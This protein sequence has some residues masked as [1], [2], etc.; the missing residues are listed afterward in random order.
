[1]YLLGLAHLPYGIVAVVT[2]F[3]SVIGLDLIRIDICYDSAP[4]LQGRRRYINIQRAEWGTTPHAGSGGVETPTIKVRGP[5]RTPF[6]LSLLLPSLYASCA[7][8]HPYATWRPLLL[9]LLV[10]M[11]SS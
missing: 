3:R 2:S 7:K 4:G 6:P 10:P 5:A 1:M 11:P 8:G 9:L